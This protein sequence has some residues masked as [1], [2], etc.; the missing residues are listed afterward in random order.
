MDDG[1]RPIGRPRNTFKQDYEVFLGGGMG[2][3]GLAKPTVVSRYTFWVDH[4]PFATFIRRLVTRNNS[5]E[6][7][8]SGT[9]VGGGLY[10][11]DP[12]SLADL[13][14]SFDQSND[15][16]DEMFTKYEEL[17]S[18]RIVLVPGSQPPPYFFNTT[19]I[20]QP[21][22]PR[23]ITDQGNF[24]YYAYGS[25]GQ[26]LARTG[27]NDFVA[28]T[29]VPTSPLLT[30]LFLRDIFHIGDY[31]NPANFR[32]I[33]VEL[34]DANRNF[35][36]NVGIIPKEYVQGSKPNNHTDANGNK[37][38]T[39]TDTWVTASDSNKYWIEI[40]EVCFRPKLP[41]KLVPGQTYYIV[42]RHTSPTSSFLYGVGANTGSGGVYNENGRYIYGRAYSGTGVAGSNSVT[43]AP[44]NV[45][46]CFTTQRN[47]GRT[48]ITFYWGNGGY[49]WA[50]PE[51]FL[52]QFEFV[53][54]DFDQAEI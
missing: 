37:I 4:N 34:W 46:L 7:Y 11:P 33:I 16:P 5:F 54:E 26:G 14:V 41:I 9:P 1:K 38:T 29:F 30:S 53:K 21:V 35:Y 8:K 19:T 39:A 12:S 44:T 43:P 3:G 31:T 36:A 27:V 18:R 13:Y 51:T 10:D 20:K 25:N 42:I 45:S 47:V 40:Q 6:I 50:D 48:A 52:G 24:V 15:R 32:D 2:A 22:D 28:Q 17:N 23:Y 49:L